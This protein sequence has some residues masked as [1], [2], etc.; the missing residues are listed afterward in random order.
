MK[1]WVVACVASLL[2]MSCARVTVDP[3]KVEPIH[4][5]MDINIKVDRQLDDFFDFEDEIEGDGSEK[6][7]SRSKGGTKGGTRE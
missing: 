1:K 3:I 5:T 6:T 2:L 4:I 7:E